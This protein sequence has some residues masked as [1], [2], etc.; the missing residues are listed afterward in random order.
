M[1]KAREFW[2][3]ETGEMWAGP[4]THE[5]LNFDPKDDGVKVIAIDRAYKKAV[6]ALKKC[7]QPC[8]E[9]RSDIIYRTLKE[10]GEL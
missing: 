1:S 2:I 7:L 10:L 5:I 9:S 6:D 4:E 3:I 8:D